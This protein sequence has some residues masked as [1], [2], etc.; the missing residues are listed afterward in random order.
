MQRKWFYYL[1]VL[2]VLFL[3]WQNAAA[4][5]QEANAFFGWLGEMLDRGFEF[6][7]NLFGSSGSNSG[8][9]DGTHST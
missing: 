8:V 9:P 5:G 1:L 3:I 4:T 7:D 6:L 2:F